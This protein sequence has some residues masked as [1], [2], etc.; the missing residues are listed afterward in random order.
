MNNSQNSFSDIVC[1]GRF[2]GQN[3]T[4]VL[5]VFLYFLFTVTSTNGFYPPPPPSKSGLK[6]VCNVNIV[7][8]NLK[9]ENSQDYA[10]KPQQNCTFMNSASVLRYTPILKYMSILHV[11]DDLRISD[12]VILKMASFLH[13]HLKV[14][15]ILLIR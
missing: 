6:L 15:L 5:K 2:L 1:R 10:Q 9:T 14:I 7:H 3:R 8:G 12:Q 11:C 4:K 13:G